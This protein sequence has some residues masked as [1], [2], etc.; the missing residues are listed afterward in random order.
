MS[1]NEMEHSAQVIYQRHGTQCTG[2]S[3]N[4]MEHVAQVCLYQLHV[5]HRTGITTCEIEH[6]AQLCLPMKF[7]TMHMFFLPPRWNTSYTDNYGPAKI[8][9]QLGYKARWMD[10]LP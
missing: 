7:N 4:A 2:M 8:Q 3:T 10:E 9:E 5:T 1:T 6:S